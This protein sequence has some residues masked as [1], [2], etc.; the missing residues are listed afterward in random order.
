VSDGAF[1]SSWD[2]QLHESS[3]PNAVTGSSARILERGGCLSRGSHP[4]KTAALVVPDF[5]GWNKEAAARA[6]G[7]DTTG[8][9]RMLCTAGGMPGT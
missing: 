2:A 4:K 5:G 6:E 8:C 1:L 7:G 3:R 9:C